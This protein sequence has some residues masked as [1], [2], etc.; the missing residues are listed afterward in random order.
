MGNFCGYA[1]GNA[2]LVPGRIARCGSVQENVAPLH[3]LILRGQGGTVVRRGDAETRLNGQSFSDAELAPGDL[4]GVG[5][6]DF[7]VVALNEG[8][9]VA[10]SAPSLDATAPP[11]PSPPTGDPHEQDGQN[12]T[13]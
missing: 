4:L 2:P 1:H 6:L 9:A 8:A 10:V 13:N 12:S 7:E 3:C 11:S 5:P